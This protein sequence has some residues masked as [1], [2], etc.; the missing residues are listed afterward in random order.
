[1]NTEHNNKMRKKSIKRSKEER[2][3]FNPVKILKLVKG[4]H[5][6]AGKQKQRCDQTHQMCV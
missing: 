1:M 2:M 6:H 3:I 4:D 5:K